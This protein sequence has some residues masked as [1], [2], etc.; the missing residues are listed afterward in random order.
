MN[1][2]AVSD[3]VVSV[4]LESIAE[5]NKQLPPVARLDASPDA[6]LTGSGARLDSLGLIN[7]IVIAEEKLEEEFGSRIGLVDSDG[8]GE[9][10]ETFSTLRSLANYVTRLIEGA[11]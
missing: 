7:F 4:L 2:P 5:L 8:V 9:R 1:Q 10:V 11:A 3:R 6:S